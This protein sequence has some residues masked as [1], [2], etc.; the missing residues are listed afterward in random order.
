MPSRKHQQMSV[1][2]KHADLRVMLLHVPDGHPLG[3]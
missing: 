2:Q 1:E 3:R